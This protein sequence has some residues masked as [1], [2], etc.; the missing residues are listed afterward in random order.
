MGSGT[1]VERLAIGRKRLSS[2]IVPGG[3][4]DG[5]PGGK[6]NTRQGLLGTLLPL[7]LKMSSWWGR[8][9]A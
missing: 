4:S 7:N 1:W 8:D 6:Q 2:A 5:V 3:R 9:R